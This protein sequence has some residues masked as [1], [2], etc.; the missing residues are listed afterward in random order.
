MADISQD[1]HT[2]RSL[3]RQFMATEPTRSAVRHDP[4]KRVSDYERRISPRTSQKWS[5]D[6]SVVSPV[7]N[8]RSK[9]KERVRRSLG[10]SSSVGASRKSI[11]PSETK[12]QKPR[13][14][15]HQHVG[16]LDTITPRTLLRKI[17]QT[18][19]EVSMI[20][21]QTTTAATAASI[22]IE[23]EEIPASVS[24]TNVGVM[25]LSVPQDQEDDH[26]TAFGNARKKRRM[27]IRQF[28]KGVDE[29]LPQTQES[30]ITQ[31]AEQSEVGSVLAN[32]SELT[33]F[34][35]INLDTPIVPETAQK[36][37]LV[38]RPKK[39][40]FVSLEDFE[41]GAHRNYN[42]LKGSQE[43][44]V[45]PE[46]EKSSPASLKTQAE[47]SSKLV[48]ERSIKM[49][50]PSMESINKNNISNR[51]ER[52]DAM[53]TLKEVSME[54]LHVLSGQKD[55]SLQ[56]SDTP[57]K[58]AQENLT[59]HTG[60]H[61]ST[62]NGHMESESNV[63]SLNVHSV[64]SESPLQKSNVHLGKMKDGEMYDKSFGLTQLEGVV[65]TNS[66]EAQIISNAADGELS[67]GVFH[68]ERM[69]AS[70]RKSKVI[71]HQ[72]VQDDWTE[73]LPLTQNLRYSEPQHSSWSATRNSISK[74]KRSIK[75]TTSF[76]TSVPSIKVRQTNNSK[77]L[78]IEDSSE[79]EGLL[80]NKEFG[81]PV[82]YDASSIPKSINSLSS[83]R[84]KVIQEVNVEDV[85]NMEEE[86]QSTCVEDSETEE[87]SMAENQKTPKKQIMLTPLANTPAYLTNKLFKI[88][89]KAQV[90]KQTRVKINT[91]GRKKKATL[92]S[93]F[94]KQ[95]FSHYA[96]MNISKETCN[97]VE[98]CLE[99]YFKQMSDDL[100]AYAAHAN[101][102][103]ITRAD[104][105]LLMKRQGLISDKM[106]IN[107]LIEQHLPL[108]YRKLLIP[109][110][111]SGNKVFPKA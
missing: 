2:T 56:K 3:L 23:Q 59:L 40:N 84:S 63:S 83:R 38:R 43:F 57:L 29:R 75:S 103:T 39:F 73:N 91:E 89:R 77:V 96:K 48:M 69:A 85:E 8:L 26:I 13:M 51:H 90:A 104:V 108:E 68:V 62:K 74:S 53:D 41:Q 33:K 81:S 107:V 28:E 19:P 24:L 101:R 94:V 11:S 36:Q 10:R 98:S 35:Q 80:V 7:K 22:S 25:D 109:C 50:Y 1:G 9:M 71:Q 49:T 27:S 42:I 18:E 37:G 52:T 64:Y 12:L 111:T 110:A 66:P 14:G 100:E 34:L 88:P 44:T 67:V 76:M 46:A 58:S 97:E 20:V 82:N 60:G 32:R 54:E 105:E 65:L 15:I 78:N 70:D 92:P 5:R 102:K 21:S 16:D 87:L 47:L 79:E 95:T 4:K 45:E 106:P 31:L 72:S 55:Q 6:D 93:S 86:R 30:S 61:K 17:I 99:L